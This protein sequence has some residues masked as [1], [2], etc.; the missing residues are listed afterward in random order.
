MTSFDFKK[1]PFFNF[2]SAL[3]TAQLKG[4][5]EYN[6]MSIATVITETVQDQTI[7]K[8]SCRVVLFK[9][10]IRGGLSFYTNY[11]GHKGEQLSLN[12]NIAATF[13]WPHLDHQVRIQGQVEK[14]TSDESDQYFWSRPRLSQIGAWASQQSELLKSTD[15]FQAQVYRYDKE[16]S[17]QRRIPRPP[18]WGGYRIIPN[19]FDFLFLK[20]GRLH[21]R[22]VYQEKSLKSANSV[23]SFNDYNWVTFLR[24]P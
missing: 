20:T 11:H 2:Q 14:L 1:D 4:I 3:N 8:P 5:P 12:P 9:G 19:E 16:F 10:F 18:H 23:Q 6:A 24:Y 22:Y 15:E 21:E 7:V 13:W 17:G